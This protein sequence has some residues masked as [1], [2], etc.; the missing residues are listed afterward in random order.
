MLNRDHIWLLWEWTED[1][2]L[3]QTL[4]SR[5]SQS[6]LRVKT[7]TTN[8]FIQLDPISL[9]GNPPI[10]LWDR[11]G[12]VYPEALHLSDWAEALGSRVINPV[13]G[14]LLARDKARLHDLL[15]KHN[16]PVPV[17]RLIRAES[18]IEELDWGCG[19]YLVLKPERSGGG[20][21]VRIQEW[22]EETLRNTM[23]SRPKE[24][25]LLQEHVEPAIIAG[26]PA[27][28]RVF[29][30]FGDIRICWWDNHTHI[31]EF[32][33]EGE[34]NA[35]GFNDLEMLGMKIGSSFPLQ[36]FSTEIVYRVDGKP[37]IVDYIND[38]CDLRCK[39][40]VYD[41]VPTELLDWVFWKLFGAA[42]ET[43]EK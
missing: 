12:D 6:G 32:L 34:V 15:V 8:E 17:T 28:F 40:H 20:E 31:Y 36:F 43:E 37:V 39:T 27:W 30:L 9:L 33:P 14:T 38:P 21:G 19:R 2:T 16:L 42:K 4:L 23:N 5:A 29:N 18:S 26:R 22:C 35:M 11:A 13:R 7:F 24:T 41:G 10:I 1:S 25:W 3:V